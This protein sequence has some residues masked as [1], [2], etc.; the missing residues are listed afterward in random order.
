MVHVGDRIRVRVKVRVRVRF[1]VIHGLRGRHEWYS[2]EIG[3]G[4]RLG[5]RLGSRSYTGCAAVIICPFL[6]L[7]QTLVGN[8]TLTLNFSNPKSSP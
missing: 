8:L 3:L 2:S 6:N 1:T 7:T 4:L 5:L